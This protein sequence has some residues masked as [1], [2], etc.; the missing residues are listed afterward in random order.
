MIYQND[1][2]LIRPMQKDD[3][4]PEYVAIFCDEKVTA[5]NSHGL[6]R[7]QRPEVLQDY[8][9]IMW[10]IDDVGTQHVMDPNNPSK[11]DPFLDVIIGSCCLQSIDWVNRSAEFAIILSSKHHGKGIGTQCL[12]WLLY[13]AFIR[14]GLNRVWSGTSRE[15]VG[16]FRVFEKCGMMAEGT[17]R[18]GMWNRGRF[19]DVLCFGILAKDYG[20]PCYSTKLEEEETPK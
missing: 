19:V 16:M 3:F 8:S 18:Q 9:K 4:T 11:Y 7:Y 13:H 14:L 17:F 1:K 6:F 2:V 20:C 15:N 12:R 10:A 5:H